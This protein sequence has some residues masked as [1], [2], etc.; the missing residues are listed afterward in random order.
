MLY[1]SLG[2]ELD[3]NDKLESMKKALS[4]SYNDL[5]YYLKNCFLYLSIFLEDKQIYCKIVIRLQTVKGFVNAIEGKTIK[6]VANGYLGELFN[7]SLIQVAKRYLDGRLFHF[8]VH[9]VMHEIIVSKAREKNIGPMDSLPIASL[10]ELFRCGSRLL[11]VL[12]FEGTSLE[13]IPDEVFKLIHLRYLGLRN[14]KV[15]MVPKLIALQ[16]KPL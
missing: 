16:E 3:G 15:K 13:T 2:A 9:G 11:N 4:L 7:K 1:R 12:D 5:P 8:H 10:H 6:E 14:T